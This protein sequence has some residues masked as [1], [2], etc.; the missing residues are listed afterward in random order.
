MRVLRGLAVAGAL[1][2]GFCAV[3]LAGIGVQRGHVWSLLVGVAAA[4]ACW[5]A[6]AR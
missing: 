3:L 4:Y 2:V 6:V 1:A 5:R